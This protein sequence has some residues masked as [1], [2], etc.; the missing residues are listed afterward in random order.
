M[1]FI[2]IKNYYNIF[3]SKEIFKYVQPIISKVPLSYI[4][5]ESLKNMNVKYGIPVLFI[6][7]GVFILLINSLGRPRHSKRSN[8]HFGVIYNKAGEVKI[9]S[10]I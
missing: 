4:C 10:L 1:Y 2:A 7:C 8:P 5:N 9:S 6:C 3:T